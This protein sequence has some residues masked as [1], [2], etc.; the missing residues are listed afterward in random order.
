[1]WFPPSSDQ[2]SRWAA[3]R[4]SPMLG[5]REGSKEVRREKAEGKEKEVKK[6]RRNPNGRTQSRKLLVTPADEVHPRI[7]RIPGVSSQQP[8]K[9]GDD[10]SHDIHN[11]SSPKTHHIY[12]PGLE[13]TQSHLMSALESRSSLA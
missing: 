8:D 4:L 1:M 13:T 3:D 5:K 9:L 12:S 11:S 2:V 7:S 6:K 10:C